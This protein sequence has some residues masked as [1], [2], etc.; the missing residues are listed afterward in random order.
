MITIS[1]LGLIACSLPVIVTLWAKSW[2]TVPPL[3]QRSILQLK[4]EAIVVLGG[5][6]KQSGNE[7]VLKSGSLMRLRYAANLARDTGLPLLLSGGGRLEEFDFSEAELMAD[8]LRNDYGVPARWLE[9]ESKNTAENAR[10]SNKILSREGIRRI[11]LVTQAYHMP[12][13]LVQFEK[14]G[15]EVLPAPTDFIGSD[16]QWDV[17]SFIP[18]VEALTN[19]FLLAHEWFGMYWY[20]L[21]Y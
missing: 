10:Y 18:S 16:E 5:G 3:P 12:R 2:E 21:R 4:P 14:Q 11:M 17:F 6:L 13:A 1:L 8:C 7:V 19:S 20:K 15:L 9:G